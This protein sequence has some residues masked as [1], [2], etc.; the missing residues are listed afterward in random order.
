VEEID[1][2]LGRL[3]DALETAALSP[4]ELAPRIRE[5][6]QKRVLTQRIHKDVSE[7]L[8]AEGGGVVNRKMILAYLSDF[9]GVLAQGTVSDVRS[10]LRSFVEAV[11]KGTSIATIRYTL[12]LPPDKITLGQETVLD[13]DSYGGLSR[14]I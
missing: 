9:D 1:L 13:F 8:A 10:L 7:T 2:R 6:Q 3:Y 4:S 11:E 14:T 12:P 5:L